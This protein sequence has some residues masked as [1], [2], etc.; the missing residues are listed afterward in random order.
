MDS[1]TDAERRSKCRSGGSE[2][3]K[4]RVDFQS[5]AVGEGGGR[6]EGEDPP[7]GRHA[8]EPAKESQTHD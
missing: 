4:L 1:W 8:E 2:L 5:Q 7:S 3:T 6:S